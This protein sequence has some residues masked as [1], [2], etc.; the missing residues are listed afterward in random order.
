MVQMLH[1]KNKLKPVE[2]AYICTA[3]VQSEYFITAVAVCT[4]VFES[5]GRTLAVML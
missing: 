5:S 3:I 1:S 2:V 4:A